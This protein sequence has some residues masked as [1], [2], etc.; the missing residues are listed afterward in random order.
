M[1]KITNTSNI[2]VDPRLMPVINKLARKRP[3]YEFDAVEI[4]AY[5]VFINGELVG[6]LSISAQYS[7]AGGT[8]DY[9]RIEAPNTISNART[10]HWQ[11]KDEAVTT[12]EVAAIRLGLEHFVLQPS[13]TRRGKLAQLIAAYYLSAKY[14]IEAKVDKV[15]RE[16]VQER[17]KA[18]ALNGVYYNQSDWSMH[19]LLSSMLL[20]TI[21]L[22]SYM[23][24]IID[25]DD[26]LK[27]N[28]LAKEYRMFT[29]GTALEGLFVEF[30]PRTGHI[31][32]YDVT[33]WKKPTHRGLF[34]GSTADRITPYLYRSYESLPPEVMQPIAMLQIS[35]GTQPILSVGAK[36]ND[37]LYFIEEQAVKAN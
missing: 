21:D 31:R 18:Q 27:W 33:H 2:L 10:L 19:S 36:I 23:S 20:G 3:Y 6:K 26:Y 5:E 22:R 8:T 1:P 12:K 16:I 14:H 37:T 29:N 28:S 34:D 25:I 13:D 9:Y 7:N 24:S 11:R 32:I 4:N 15:T 35:G 17:S 30:M